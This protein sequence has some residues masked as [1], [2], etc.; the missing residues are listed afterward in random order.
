MGGRGGGGG[1]GWEEVTVGVGWRLRGDSGK[2]TRPV[3][4]GLHQAVSQT[5]HVPSHDGRAAVGKSPLS[6]PPSRAKHTP[7]PHPPALAIDHGSYSMTTKS[8]DPPQI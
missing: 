4:V 3:V 1:R 5:I 7:P 6:T 2:S 8:T